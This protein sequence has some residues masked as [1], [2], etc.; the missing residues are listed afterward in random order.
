MTIKEELQKVLDT[1]VTWDQNT[2]LIDFCQPLLDMTCNRNY[3]FQHVIL[4]QPKNIVIGISKEGNR[5]E[6]GPSLL[7]HYVRIHDHKIYYSQPVMELT[8]LIKALID[9]H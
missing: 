6:E 3:T 1:I 5:L 9:N 8:N 7:Q 2:R 4:G